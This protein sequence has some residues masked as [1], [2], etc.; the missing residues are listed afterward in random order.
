MISVFRAFDKTA[1]KLAP[2]VTIAISADQVILTDDT[3]MPTPAV[4]L[5][6]THAREV[7]AR[8]VTLATEIDDERVGFHLNR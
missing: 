2:L 8:I 6:P 4:G 5:D 1:G 3:N 7:A